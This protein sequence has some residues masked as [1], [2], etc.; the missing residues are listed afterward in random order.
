MITQLSNEQAV[1]TVKGEYKATPNVVIYNSPN[2]TIKVGKFYRP[3]NADIFTGIEITVGK[4]NKG[5]I[6]Y[7]VDR[8][9]I[10]RGFTLTRT[11]VDEEPQ[12]ID[13]K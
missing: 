10:P 1:T 4:D 7:K 11:D 9:R 5:G 13:I 3:Q 2:T 8:D 12:Y 6:L